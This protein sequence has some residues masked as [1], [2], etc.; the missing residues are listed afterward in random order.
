MC[1]AWRSSSANSVTPGVKPCAWWNNTISA[2]FKYPFCDC[3]NY[4]RSMAALAVWR[5]NQPEKRTNPLVWS[6]LQKQDPPAVG[7]THRWAAAYITTL[8][9][10]IHSL[11]D[12]TTHQGLPSL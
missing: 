10:N 6:Q 4:W 3:Y 9:K 5:E 8:Q 11:A 2:I 12:S 1:P 7:C